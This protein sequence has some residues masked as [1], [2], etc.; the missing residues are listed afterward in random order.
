MDVDWCLSC[1]CRIDPLTAKGPYCSAEC[2]SFAEP[3]SSSRIMAT[4]PAASAA[5]RI[6]EWLQT[7]PPDD[8]AGAPALPSQDGASTSPISVRSPKPLPQHQPELIKRMAGATPRPT[9]SVSS[10]TQVRA[11]HTPASSRTYSQAKST[12]PSEASTSLTSLLSEPMVVTPAEECRFGT[13]ISAF[14]PP[15]AHRDRTRSTAPRE[16]AVK[17]S[18]YYSLPPLEK[19]SSSSEFKPKKTPSP[20]PAVFVNRK[21]PAK[22]PTRVGGW[23]STP[24]ETH[25]PTPVIFPSCRSF[26]VD[27][28]EDGD[29]FIA[30]D[31]QYHPAY[32]TKHEASYVEEEIV[33]CARPPS[34]ARSTSSTGSSVLF[35]APKRRGGIHGRVIAPRA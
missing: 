21:P 29:I 16:G 18:Y 31:S 3:S 1:S 22:K 32:R 23:T 19:G 9:L 15:W 33:Y 34:P 28:D 4:P 14:V 8:P 6:R 30:P 2:L 12:T 13:G 7:I 25:T 27:W 11:F 10:P 24:T 26:D 17:N 20:R 5:C 35:M